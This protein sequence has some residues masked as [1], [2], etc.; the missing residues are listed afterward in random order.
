MKAKFGMMVV[1]GR[2][3]LGGHVLSKSR[4]GAYA[5]TKVSGVNPQ[6]SY[7]LGARSLLTALSQSWRALTQE[8]RDGWD[9]AVAGYAKTDVFGDLRNP[10]G[11]NL[12]TRLNVNLANA[13]QVMIEDA[14]NPV[15]AGAVTAGT[16]VITNGGAKTIA[17]TDDT[18]G[19]TIQ[20]WATPGVSAGKKF[21][22][23]QYRLISTFVGGASSPANIAAA[24]EARFGDPAVGTR[25]NVKLVSVNNDTGETSTASE[26]STITV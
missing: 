20:V 14:P 15:G 9:N 26:A 13:G 17:H 23:N 8:Q 3:K 1:D 11:K 10:T 18:A 22:K 25:V 19:H 4:S 24:Y 6:T 16:L 21:V 5:R 7:Q 12:Y 2:G